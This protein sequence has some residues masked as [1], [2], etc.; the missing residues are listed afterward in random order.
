ML[1]SHRIEILNEM[2]ERLKNE[3]HLFISDVAPLIGSGF[4]EEES[5]AEYVCLKI[6]L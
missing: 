5:I 4:F 3:K 6:R 2:I 1:E